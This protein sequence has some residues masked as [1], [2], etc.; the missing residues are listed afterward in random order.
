MSLFQKKAKESNTNELE[1][2]VISTTRD[3]AITLDAYHIWH[4]RG[5]ELCS[6]A[7]SVCW[8]KKLP[9]T[10]EGLVD[11]LRRRI[12]TGHTSIL[13]HSN[14]VCMVH[15]PD[16]QTAALLEAVDSMRYLHHVCRHYN[17]F[18]GYAV[19]IGGSYRAYRDFFGTCPVGNPVKSAITNIVSAYAPK[20]I[21]NDQIEAGFI[22]DRWSSDVPYVPVKDDEC[23]QKDFNYIDAIGTMSH[24]L[25]ANMT[26]IG[27]IAQKVKEFTLERVFSMH[28]LMPMCTATVCFYDLSRA[29]THQLVRHRNGITQESQRYVDYSEA[30]FTN[31]ADLKPEKYD[32]EAKYPIDL[33]YGD[34]EA[35]FDIPLGDLGILIQSIYPQLRHPS[36][37]NLEPLIQEDARAYL[38]T[39]IK[40]RKIYITYTM[41]YLF[42]FLVLRMAK[43]AQVEIRNF[44]NT[45]Y[46]ALTST[47]NKDLIDEPDGMVDLCGYRLAFEAKYG[48]SPEPEVDE[49]LSKEEMMGKY[50][51]YLVQS[52]EIKPD[53]KEE[54]TDE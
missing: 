52:G 39:N 45:L 23:Y 32:A 27:M 12:D 43:G 18:D 35:H 34:Q 10:Y 53:Q 36:D 54:K 1:S 14:I 17:A 5:V 21:F 33:K 8:D 25:L 38:P 37:P 51:D 11:Y 44:A 49:P 20:A 42:R 24:I 40:C 2:G 15:V 28:D 3:T 29:G 19:L 13:E 4:N 22:I 7:C 47:C 26:N 30:L 50:K 48:G 6:E 9:N 16:V 46:D 41:D 31:P